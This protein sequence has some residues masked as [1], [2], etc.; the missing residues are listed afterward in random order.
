MTMNVGIKPRKNFKLSLKQR[1][2]LVLSAVMGVAFLG[3]AG[4]QLHQNRAAAM[5]MQIVAESRRQVVFGTRLLEMVSEIDRK[6]RSKE[7]YEWE[8]GQFEQMLAEFSSSSGDPAP[9][10]NS[11]E[12][13]ELLT[14]VSV[15]FKNYLAAV[16]KYEQAAADT[17][18]AT[19]GW[20]AAAN[21]SSLVSA[22]HNSYQDLT[23]DIATLIRINE[24]GTLRTWRQ[25]KSWN[26][27]TSNFTY[28][29]LGILV[30]LTFFGGFMVIAAITEPLSSLVKFLDAV[31]IE[32]D[33]PNH[34]P[35]LNSELPEIALVAKSF[36]QLLQRLRVYRNLNVKR[37]LIE[38]RRA[39]IIAASISDGIFLLR[40]DEILYTNPV[41]E[42]M[43]AVRKPMGEKIKTLAENNPAGPRQT[44]RCA[45]AILSA[46]SQTMPVEFSTEEQEDK[47]HYR[48]SRKRCKRRL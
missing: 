1:I 34:I 7:N 43:L 24:D 9:S 12:L 10:G 16:E 23:T 45:R 5:N 29:L 32:D 20:L 17:D 40:G 21:D 38:K 6:S 44:S 27:S 30:I 4:V 42:R 28:Y 25:L 37:L 39:D 13:K 41:A 8:V 35:Q 36:E 11:D 14:R 18:T 31:N 15:K 22:I 2:W 33:L 48:T 19:P 26:E 47:T 46:I 3:A